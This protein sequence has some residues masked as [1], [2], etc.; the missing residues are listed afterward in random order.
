MFALIEN[1]T[2]VRWVSLFQEYPNFSFPD[3]VTGDCL[4]DNVVMVHE[5]QPPIHSP[6]M[7]VQTND[8]PE[9]L[10]GAWRIT[11]TARDM[12]PDEFSAVTKSKMSVVKTERNRLLLESDWSQLPDSNVDKTAWAQYRQQLREITTQSGFPWVVE[13]PTKP[14]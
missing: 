4:P 9:F 1:D 8:V 6:Q 3:P 12:T 14:D 13:F 11:H 2:F 7:V 10:D 5:T